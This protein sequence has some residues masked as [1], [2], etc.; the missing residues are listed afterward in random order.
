M[1]I[2]KYASLDTAFKILE[3][4]RVLLN[5]PYKFKDITD[6][7]INISK[8]AERKTI[9][10]IQNYGMFKGLYDF[11]HSLDL[12]KPF[13]GKGL[14]KWVK[15]EM[16]IY[17]KALSLD[18]IYKP[19]RFLNLMYFIFRRKLPEIEELMK[20]SEYLYATKTIPNIVGL[21]QKARISCFSKTPTNMYC[22]NEHAEGHNGICIEFEEDRS[23]F[24]DVEYANESAEMDIYYTTARI[25]AHN[26]LNQEL[27]YHDK[28]FA[29]AMLRPFFVKNI[30][31]K[32]EDEVRCLLSDNEP[33][34][35][36]YVVEDRKTFLKMKITRVYV[37]CRIPNGDELLK[38]L[39]LCDAKSIPISYMNFNEKKNCVEEVTLSK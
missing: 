27:T 6:S 20:R 37:G 2:Y 9:K 23:F 19:M 32:P 15:W 8:K 26:L 11:V 3:Q 17:L 25:L 24:E 4:E 30:S 21:R 16:K 12:T 28:D 33:R 13:R 38:F 22:W 5:S 34:T 29:K 31:Y 18:K 7:L 1:K 36:G 39:K 14:V 10:L 35:V